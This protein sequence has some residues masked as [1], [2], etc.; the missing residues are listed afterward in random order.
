[1][2]SPDQKL[3]NN[4][5]IVKEHENDN[6]FISNI[7][8]KYH[9]IADT[10]IR[11]S[12]FELLVHDKHV[13]QLY[14]LLKSE[15]ESFSVILQKMGNMTDMELIALIDLINL[16]EKSG[17]GV[18]DLKYHSFVRPLSGA[19][20]TLGSNPTFSLTKTNNIGE[21]KAFEVG[22]CRYCNSLYIIGKIQHSL[23]DELDYLFQNKEVDTDA[24]EVYTLCARCGSIYPAANLNAR[25][26]SCGESFKRIIYRVSQT[27]I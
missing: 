18:F 4:I 9:V 2:S 7:C 5:C 12:L 6:S 1:M 3:L 15:A 23:V 14:E 11:T 25:K 26:C 22:N 17:I 19:F 27:L 16:A 24:L 10:D 21:L 13:H 20:I 8:E